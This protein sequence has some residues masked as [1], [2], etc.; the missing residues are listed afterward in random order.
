MLD[1][2]DTPRKGFQHHEAESEPA[3]NPHVAAGAAASPD[4]SA[5]DKQ[6]EQ[7]AQADSGESV[8][9]LEQVELGGDRVQVDDKRIINCRADVN[10]LV[11]FKYTWA[12]DKYLSGCANHW[13]PSEINMSADI[14]T[15]N[16]P[17]GLDRK[18]TRLKSSH[19]AI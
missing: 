14:A 8:T 7:G 1:F 5:L 2:E 3:Y 19:V 16:N 17:N 11:P 15:W 18:S 10:Q 12:W 9:G 6:A 4:P 13:M